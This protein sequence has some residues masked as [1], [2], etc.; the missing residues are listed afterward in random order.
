MHIVFVTHYFT[1]EVNAPAQRAHGLAKAWVGQGC[2]VT[3][4]T[5]APSHP[6]GQVYDGY[7]NEKTEEWVDGIRVLRL[8]TTLGANAGKFRRARNYLSFLTAVS[9]NAKKLGDVD[10]VISTSPHLLCGLSGLFASWRIK[11]PWVIEVRDIWPDSIVAVGATGD[12]LIIRTLSAIVRWA[13]HR[14]DKVVSVSPGF[15]EH[16][17]N[18]GLPASKVALIPNG[19]DTN[20]APAP[21]SFDDIP[22]LTPLRDRFIAAYLGT[23]G[24]AHSVGTILDAA[25]LLKDNHK[26]GFLI[27]GSGAE[28]DVIFQRVRDENLQNVVVMDQ[29]PK[30]RIE[31]IWGLVSASIV[32]LKDHEVFK[33]VIPTKLLEGLSMGRPIL[34]GIR[35]QAKEILDASEGGIAFE[36]ENASELV[37]ALETLSEDPE[38]ARQFGQQG[39]EFVR[40]EFNRET[41]SERYLTLLRQITSTRAGAAQ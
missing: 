9:L 18:Q 19:I 38:S 15:A 31:Q 28:R 23:I 39:R 26:I 11:S 20:R 7:K 3:I 32:L 2:E 41:L 4:V 6:Y 37:S 24:M 14:S 27:A 1:P 8:K 35:G 30:H 12:N 21:A 22:E 36:P 33:T 34:L 40:A 5:A 17:A 16:F 29:Q 10:I 13:Y 25:N